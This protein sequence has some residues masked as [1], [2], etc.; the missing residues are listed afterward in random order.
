VSADG[1][2][3]GDDV[4]KRCV[5][6]RRLK[7]S[8]VSDAVTLDGK[9]FQ[10]RGAAT[11]NSRSPIFIPCCAQESDAGTFYKSAETTSAEVRCRLPNA[12]LQLYNWSISMS[13]DNSTW[14]N[15]TQVLVYDP[16]YVTCDDDGNETT[17]LPAQVY[18]THSSAPLFVYPPR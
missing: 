7:V 15:I 18:Q 11:N 4:T 12:T 8:S 2:S 13:N 5:F 6:R 17:C 9:V 3:S 10:T 16:V 14:S 1:K